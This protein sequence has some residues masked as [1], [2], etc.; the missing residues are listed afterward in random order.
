M[1]DQISVDEYGVFV[2]KLIKP[3]EEI[4][5][6]ITPEEANLWHLATG[7]AGE[8]GELLDAIKKHVI[9]KKPQDL[10][11]IIEELG[12]LEFYMEGLRQALSLSRNDII[13]KNIDKLSIRYGNTY[14]NKSAIDRRDKK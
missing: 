6:N 14:S 11:N 13:L 10:N 12:D 8:A 4:A 5:K 9:Y 7:I 3:G 1:T 2:F